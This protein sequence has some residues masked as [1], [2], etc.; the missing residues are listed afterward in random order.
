MDWKEVAKDFGVQ[1]EWLELTPKAA[2][3]IPLQRMAAEIARLKKI[4]L[5][6]L[7]ITSRLFSYRA[8]LAQSEEKFNAISL[9]A[10]DHG[11]ARVI[12]AGKLKESEEK[13]SKLREALNTIGH[14]QFDT[15]T[16]VVTFAANVGLIMERALAADEGGE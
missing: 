13:R 8:K 6:S 12:L 7:D 14:L 5:V 3:G 1:D 9:I 15:H 10:D 2:F 4:E 11:L 16:P